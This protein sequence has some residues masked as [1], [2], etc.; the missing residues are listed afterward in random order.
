MR[1]CLQIASLAALTVS[2]AA[3][4]AMQERAVESA[5]TLPGQVEP[6]YAAAIARDHAIF[7]VTSNGCTAKEDL[8]PVVTEV[9]AGSEITLRRLKDDRCRSPQ[10]NG[11]E[12]R[13]TFEE[14]GLPP[15]A[16]LSVRNPSQVAAPA[17]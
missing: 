1:R 11:L 7:W 16:R 3:C 2:L 10:P 4:A 8:R 9:G 6:V 15:G 5:A 14:L 17:V 13:W 12:V